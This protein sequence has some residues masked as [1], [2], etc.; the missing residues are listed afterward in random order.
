MGDVCYIVIICACEK[1][2]LPKSVMYSESYTICLWV[3]TAEMQSWTSVIYITYLDG[4]LSL[5]PSDAICSCVFRMKDDREV[6]EWFDIF[7][8]HAVPGEWAYMC[9][10][11]DVI[12]GLVRLYFNGMLIGSKDRA[13]N[14]KVPEQIILGGDEYQKSFHGKVAGLEIYHCVLPEAEIERKFRAFQSD[15]TFLGTKGKK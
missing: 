4:F 5:V 9:V 12:T 8:R 11:C 10:S 1:T 13:P 6:N 15:P 2:E 7:G 14:L 3:N